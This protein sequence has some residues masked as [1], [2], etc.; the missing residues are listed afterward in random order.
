MKRKQFMFKGIGKKRQVGKNTMINYHEYKKIDK[1]TQSVCS[2]G[3][4]EVDISVPE[5]TKQYFYEMTPIF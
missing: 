3:A 5:H 4:I 2:F 1:D